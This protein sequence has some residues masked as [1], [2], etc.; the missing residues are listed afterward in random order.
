MRLSSLIFVM[1]KTSLGA[2]SREDRSR[3]YK[4]LG[5][6]MSWGSESS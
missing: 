6:K 5:G 3:V 4:I 1:N 2:G